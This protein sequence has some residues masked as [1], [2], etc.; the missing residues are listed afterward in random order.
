MTTS[1]QKTKA[2]LL[3]SLHRS[4]R[5]LILPNIWDSLGAR[6]LESKG[7]RV[8]ATSSSAISASL[9]YEDGEKLLLST[10][11]DILSR[12][13]KSVNI[14]V[15]AD[16]ESGYGDTLAEL[17]DAIPQAI[18]TG[19][20]GV[21]I[22]DSVVEGAALRPINEQCERI[23]ALRAVA[24]KQDLHLV[25]NARTDCFLSH[26]YQTWE[27][28]VEETITR[29][30]AYSEAG[31]DCIYPIGVG[32]IETLKKLRAGIESPINVLA[33]PNAVP[34]I[35]LQQIGINRV[36]F[37]PFIFRSCLKK[38]VDI[39]DSVKASEGYESFGS[40]MMSRAEVN[41]F[42]IEEHEK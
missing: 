17:E 37:G 15:S 9:G 13:T 2:E 7:F 6:I 23:A 3:L 34:L 28:K 33:E 41:S 21:N 18:E 5:I 27:E 40:N 39:V 36:S 16:I 25:I 38:F 42:L 12:I 26:T 31:A 20:A 30:M 14:P 35:V 1:A 32:D 19:I 24:S 29:A 4:G 11:L 10:V 8:A 22:E